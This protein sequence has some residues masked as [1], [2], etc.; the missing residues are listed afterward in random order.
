MVRTP[1]NI[2]T[3]EKFDEVLTLCGDI[4]AIWSAETTTDRDRKEIVRTIISDVVL[5]ERTPEEFKV[6]VRWADGA[7]D[8]QLSVKRNAYAYRIIDE[9][10]AQGLDAEAIAERL[11]DMGLRTLKDNAWT[12]TSIVMAHWR[13][14]KRTRNVISHAACRARTSRRTPA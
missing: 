7:P 8:E 13:R 9:L 6:R 1:A 4:G 14:G 11:N 3:E 12:K 2:F 5:E 10:A